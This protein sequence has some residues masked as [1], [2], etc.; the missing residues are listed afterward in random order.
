VIW[1]VLIE[2][3]NRERRCLLIRAF[4]RD[5]YFNLILLVR[6]NKLGLWRDSQQGGGV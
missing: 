5:E 2:E 6:K 1:R 3:S 4:G